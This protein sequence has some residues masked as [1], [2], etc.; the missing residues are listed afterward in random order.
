[1]KLFERVTGSGWRRGPG[2]RPSAVR[3]RRCAASRLPPTFSSSTCCSGPA[4]RPSHEER[5]THDQAL[6]RSAGGRGALH[7]RPAS[8]ADCRV[9]H[10]EVID[11]LLETAAEWAADLILVGHSREHNGRRALARRLAMKAPCSVWMR[12][13]FSPAP[14]AGCWPQSI[15]RSI[16]HT[17]SP[18]P[19]G[20]PPAPE[21]PS[22]W[23]CTSIST[24]LL[25]R[26]GVCGAAA[27][28]RTGGVRALRRAARYGRRCRAAVLRRESRYRESGGA[29]GADPR[30]RPGGDGQ[31][32]EDS[33]RQHSAGQRVGAHAHDLAISPC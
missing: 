24:N 22:A 2:C 32:R 23:R 29:G 20:S 10:G 7:S 17:P 9:L 31:P 4:P 28:Q 12:P 30:R 11:C 14:C 25:R 15:I 16:L 27:G 19:A 21:A 1:M 33:V 18:S 5:T 3:A 8:A 6:G 13:E 26:A